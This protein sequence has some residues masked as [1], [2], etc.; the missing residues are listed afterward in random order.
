M[1]VC[2]CVRVVCVSPSSA[3]GRDYQKLFFAI[4]CAKRVSTEQYNS[5]LGLGQIRC[6]S[7]AAIIKRCFGDGVKIGRF[8]SLGLRDV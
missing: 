5:W 4:I 2:V 7:R 8:H 1:C 3:E 6:S